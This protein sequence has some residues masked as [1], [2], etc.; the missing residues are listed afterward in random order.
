MQDLKGNEVRMDSLVEGFS[1]N[2][3]KVVKGRVFALMM[4]NHVAVWV[5]E[6]GKAGTHQHVLYGGKYLVRDAPR[7][8]S[9]R[10]DI[11]EHL[12]RG[13]Q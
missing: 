3:G 4:N 1:S 6:A 12:K 2:T 13:R 5:E 8:E 7:P 11:P 10:G 9:K